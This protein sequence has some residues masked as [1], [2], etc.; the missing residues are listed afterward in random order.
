MSDAAR[1]RIIVPTLRNHEEL[2]I[3]LQGLSNQ[4]WEGDIGVICVGPTDDPGEMVAEEFGA[5]WIDDEG[6][7]TRADACNVALASIDCD[8]VLFTDDD[9]W[10][11]ETWVAS[12]VGWFDRE[13]VAGVGGPNFAPP[14]SRSTFW[15]RVIDVTFCSRWVTAGTNYGNRGVNDLEEVEQL[16]GVNAAYRKSVLD[17]VGGFDQGAIGCEDAMLD[18]R[19]RAAGHRLWQDREAIIWHRRRNPPRVRKQIENYGLVRILAS[20]LHPGMRTWSHI[21]VGL[22]PPFLLL[23]ILSF[24]WGVA[25]GGLAW[26]AF[27]DI[28]TAAVPMGVPRAAVHTP[29]SLG[30]IYLILCWLGAAFGTSPSKSATTVIAAPLMTL[31]MHLSYGR[32]VLRAWWR[33][34]ITGKLGLQIDDKDRA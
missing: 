2:A 13:E 1:V 32:G 24:V 20:H 12:L 26:P 18:Y 9:V 3:V 5:T 11:P 10:V 25:N 14:D 17:E 33:I 22:F 21:A 4:T 27:W 29:S 28:S 19:I 34:R 15:Q 6:S 30:A 7:R 31:L 23:G 8:L 16:P